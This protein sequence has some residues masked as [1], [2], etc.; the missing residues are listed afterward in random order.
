MIGV[1]V[2]G[3]LA[4]LGVYIHEAISAALYWLV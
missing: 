2:L 1:A 3:A 4:A